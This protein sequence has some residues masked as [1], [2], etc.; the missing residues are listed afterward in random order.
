MSTSRRCCSALSRG[1]F[2]YTSLTTAASRLV[3]LDASKL[4]A[5]PLE[6]IGVRDTRNLEFF[7]TSVSQADPVLCI[8][9]WD[10]P[11]ESEVNREC[12]CLEDETNGRVVKEFSAL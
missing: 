9:E 10:G 12:G 5:H 1:S 6:E 2:V 11:C 4:S 3:A 7:R 8:V